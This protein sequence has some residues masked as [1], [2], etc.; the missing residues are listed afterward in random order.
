MKTWSNLL[1]DPF[2]EFLSGTSCHH[3]SRLDSQLFLHHL[4]SS[5]FPNVLME[6]RLC[7]H[8]GPRPC[9]H[10]STG[11]LFSTSRSSVRPHKELILLLVCFSL[12][13][14]YLTLAIV[15]CYCMFSYQIMCSWNTRTVL[16]ILAFLRIGTVP[17]TLWDL[18]IFTLIIP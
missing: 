18:V 2:H 11:F 15:T 5:H 9:V 8:R 3:R 12:S 1:C 17:D 10:E 14:A 13:C 6:P 16:L 7:L 4:P